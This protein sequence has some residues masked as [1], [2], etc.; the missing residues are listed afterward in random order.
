[1]LKIIDNANMQ[2]PDQKNHRTTNVSYFII[3]N[4]QLLKHPH[5]LYKY[6][7]FIQQM[8]NQQLRDFCKQ[9]LQVVIS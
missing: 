6:S 5:Q 1:M 7:V 4:I 9:S 3:C 2:L 8:N